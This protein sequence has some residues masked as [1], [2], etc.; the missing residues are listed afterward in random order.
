MEVEE[1]PRVPKNYSS[2]YIE[3]NRNSNK[4][5]RIIVLI[6][7]ALELLFH[8]IIGESEKYVTTTDAENIS[9]ASK[10]GFLLALLV[11]VPKYQR[12]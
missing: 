8:W 3:A 12:I 4:I 5:G 9:A 2:L 1:W 7:N 10:I 11:L 6:Q